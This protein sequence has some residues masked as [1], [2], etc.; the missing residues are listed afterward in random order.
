MKNQNA[1][2][3]KY[4]HWTVIDVVMNEKRHEYEWICMCDCGNIVQQRT[5]NVKSGKSKQCRECSSKNKVSK[6]PK[7]LKRENTSISYIG[8]QYGELIVEDDYYDKKLKCRIFKC[9][10]SCGQTRLAKRYKVLNGEITHCAS[11]IHRLS[12]NNTKYIGY[13]S[14][15]LTVKSFVYDENLQMIKW[16]C[17]CSCGKTRE[18]IPYFIKHNLATAC[19]EC[20]NEKIRLQNKENNKTHGLSNER[21]YKI[22]S[23]MKA[24]CY[25]PKNENYKNYGGRGIS[26]CEEWRNDFLPFYN[27]AMDNGYEDYLTID[28]INNDGNY[29]P[30]NCRWAT[31]KQQANN[32]RNP[33]P[34]LYLT[35]DGVKK[36]IIEWAKESEFTTPAIM[37]RLNTK[38]MSGKEAV[39]GERKAYQNYVKWGEDL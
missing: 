26:I 19:I 12:N 20:T 37:Y 29:E 33:T 9:K 30:N 31:Y 25:N 34:K 16:V 24:R 36:P 3:E 35:I 32:K 1:I 15:D 39:F 4:N 28:R 10:C 14:G 21:L 13:K 6:N 23:G 8:K 27:W 22:W 11:K 5:Y 18:V 2:G 7:K 17:E 38:H